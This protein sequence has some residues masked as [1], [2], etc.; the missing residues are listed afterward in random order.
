MNFIPKFSF[1]W[2]QQS[3]ERREAKFR[4]GGRERE[5][6]NRRQVFLLLSL[7]NNHHQQQQTN[8]KIQNPLTSQPLERLEEK[9]NVAIDFVQAKNA[10]LAGAAHRLETIALANGTVPQKLSTLA[11]STHSAFDAAWMMQRDAALRELLDDTYWYVPD[12]YLKAYLYLNGAQLPALDQTVWHLRMARDPDRYVFGRSVVSFFPANPPA[13][14]QPSY[15][16]NRMLGSI[17]PSGSVYISFIPTSSANDTAVTTGLGSFGKF[18]QGWAFEMQ[19]GSGNPDVLAAHWAYMVQCERGDP[20]FSSLPGVG[21]SIP[22]F[23][24]QCGW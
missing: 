6:E 8:R 21:I 15:G 3:L 7:S 9:S 22:E 19:M 16:C 13:G 2:I 24:S 14:Y 10:E 1:C 4:G 23:M 5:K 18:K 20:C 12:A 11:D 17:A